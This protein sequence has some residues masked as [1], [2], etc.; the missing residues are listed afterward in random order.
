MV[1]LAQAAQTATFNGTLPS[2]AY[3][4]NPTAGHLLVACLRVRGGGGGSTPGT[5]SGWTL[6]GR[7]GSTSD[8]DESNMWWRI[9]PGG[10]VTFTIPGGGPTNEQRLTL[11]EFDNAGV[12]S[13]VDSVVLNA[14]APDSGY[15]VGDV[16][17]T[18]HAV[19]VGMVVTNDPGGGR[20]VDF[21]DDAAFTEI[22]QGSVFGTLTPE[23]IVSYRD[24]GAGSFAYIPNGDEV[25]AWG[26]ILAAFEI[27]AAF[28]ADF[29]GTP[30]VGAPGL[31]VAFT[32]ESFGGTGTPDTWLWDFGD[33]TTSTTQDPTHVYGIAGSY[34]VSLTATTDDAETDTETKVAYV[35]VG[36]VFDPP[37]PS[38]AVIE[39]YAASPGSARWGVALWGESVWS[40]AGWQD[41]TPQSVDATVRW[42]SHN[43]ERGI[44]TETEAAS[45]I[46]NTY[47][48]E[49]LL[50]PGNDDGPYATDLRAGLPIRI[51]HRG[52]IVRQGVAE[53]IAYFHRDKRGGIR[54][55]DVLSLMA[56]TPVPEDS[57]L[58][59]TLR[60][61]ARDAIAAAGLSITVEPDPPTGDPALAPRL[62]GDRSVWRHLADAGQQTLHI[63][64]VDRI[65]TVKFRPWATPYDRARGVDASQLVDLGTVVSTAGLYSVVQA[66]ET[67]ADGG[68]TIERRLTPTPQYGSVVY[69][70]AEETLDPDAWAD[71]VLA[72]RSLQ[73]VQWIPGQIYPLSATAVEYFA[74]LE[75]IER[76][77]VEHAYTDPA[78]D[79]TGI[80]VGGEIRVRSQREAEAI[81]AFQLELAQTAQS[82]LYTD[83]DPPEFL[84]N[85][86]GDGYLYPG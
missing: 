78:V 51:R 8:P 69:H 30:L 29:S 31:S 80:I 19:I 42:G 66:D 44:L 84:R 47:D 61:R 52:T 28:T 54:A 38:N 81:W 83:T 3:A 35:K 2:L 40:A 16:D 72:D 32:D 43:P 20:H 36:A 62:E 41:V 17:V 7:A 85:E 49:R 12:P 6:V 73:T 82:P 24:V 57:I 21:T 60:A 1:A 11:I 14:Q 34:A 86:A 48:P 63:A 25:V 27:A 76:F 39:I 64:Y 75:A 70:R 79:I 45:W 77:E 4:T 71:A 37:S 15:S 9:A 5:P 55:T 26:G 13:L 23:S 56:R 74:T 53:S 68:D 67:D 10:A 59:D 46:V 33:G 65:G 50:D 58:A 22:D 18:D